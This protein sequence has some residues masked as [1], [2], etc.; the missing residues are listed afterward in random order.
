VPL[1]SVAIAVNCDVAPIAGADPVTAIDDTVVDDVGELPHA[2]ATITHA[3]AI[4][5]M[6]IERT[7]EILVSTFI[8]PSL[9]FGSAATGGI[10]AGVPL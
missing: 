6:I 7:F 3:A 9:F 5:A 2:T 1:L 10:A 4:V 8:T